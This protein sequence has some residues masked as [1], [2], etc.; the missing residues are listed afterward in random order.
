MALVAQFLEALEQRVELG[1]RQ[2]AVR[3]ADRVT[4]PCSRRFA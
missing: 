4:T 2:V 3:R 1:A